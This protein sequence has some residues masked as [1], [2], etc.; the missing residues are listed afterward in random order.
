MA[1]AGDNKEAITGTGIMRKKT[2]A[3]LPQITTPLP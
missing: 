3:K 2:V 1:G